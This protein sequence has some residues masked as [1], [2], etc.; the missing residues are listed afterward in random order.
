VIAAVYAHKST[1]Q[2][3][4]DEEKSVTRQIEHARAYAMKKGWTV[5][6]T[7]SRDRGRRPRC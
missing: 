5:D 1:E 2:N 6:E 4:S 7:S 3:T